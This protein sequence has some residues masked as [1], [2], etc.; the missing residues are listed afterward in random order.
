MAYTLLEPHGHEADEIRE[1]SSDETS[2]RESQR[3][4]TSIPFAQA[5]IA[6]MHHIHDSEANG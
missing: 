6:E 4:R 3:H 1:G 5:A 2:Q